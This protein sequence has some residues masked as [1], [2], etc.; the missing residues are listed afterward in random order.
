MG[1]RGGGEA[2]ATAGAAAIASL[3]HF[4]K[5]DAGA[6]PPGEGHQTARAAA[7]GASES[8]CGAP[9]ALG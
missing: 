7:A 4:T 3:S 5:K 1:K 2:G 9:R 8:V 6:R